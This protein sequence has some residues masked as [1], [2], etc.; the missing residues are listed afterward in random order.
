MADSGITWV[1]HAAARQGRVGGVLSAL[2]AL[3]VQ[4]VQMDWQAF[5][6]DYPRRRLACPLIPSNANGTGLRLRNRLR[7]PLAAEGHPLLGRSILSPRLTDIVHEVALGAWTP[8]YLN[9]HRIFGVRVFPAT[10][11]IE[12]VRAAL[13]KLSESDCRIE[14]M[15]VENALVCRRRARALC[16]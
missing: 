12:A 9:D 10:G 14:E 16:N 4:G 7:A 11:Y 1:A 3:Y 13:A 2:G 5:D 15:A 8:A 6:R